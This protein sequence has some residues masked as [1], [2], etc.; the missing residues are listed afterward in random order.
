MT[1]TTDLHSRAAR[2]PV[3][4]V[5]A[6][7]LVEITVI[8]TVF[9]HFIAFDCRQN[10]PAEYCSAASRALVAIYCLLGVAVLLRMLRPAPLATLMQA[11]GGRQ[12]PLLINAA[13]VAVALIPLAFLNGA[14]GSDA[15]LPA[16][17]LW[18]AGM[19]L[20]LAGVA[21]FIAPL[22]RWGAY[23]R[24][25]W[26]TILPA[27]VLASA[28]PWISIQLQPIWSIAWIADRT[29]NAVAALMERFGYDLYADPDSKVIG[30]GEFYVIVDKVCSGIEG[31]ALVTLFVS[32]YL[33][34]F[35]RELRFP[36]A[37]LLYPIG[38]AA[39]VTFNVIRITV[40]LII[41]LEGNPELAV[42][43]FH[44][45]AGWMMFTVVALGLIAF[46]QMV[47][48]LRKPSV[49]FAATHS[50]LPPFWRDPTVAMILPFIVFMLSALL[51]STLSQVPS[52]IY[53]AR[54]AVMVAVMALLLPFYRS[55]TWRIDSVAVGVGI[56]IAAYWVLIPV[57]STASAAPYGTLSGALLLGWFVARGVGTI[58]LVPIIEELFFRG[59]LEPRLRLGGGLPWMIG[60]ALVSAALF[61][62]LHGRVAE[63]FVAGLLFSWVAARR[64]TVTDAIIAH[65]VANAL[66]FFTAIVASN[67]AMI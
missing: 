27:G 4:A 26:T 63:A 39:S 47:P 53:P 59:Y 23:L 42:G 34:L 44:S 13:G 14:Q 21:L 20:M 2:L 38:I 5:L 22:S 6:L 54:V 30:A 16:L 66:I 9:K 40:L 41:G 65:S 3:L 45:H 1:M 32:L 64:G 60:A 67:M 19:S 35:R 10:W 48:V 43:G 24:S 57:E 61:A 58:A 51:A 55:L 28:A 29:F 46:A 11:A 50:P 31:I 49:G 56:F 7:L 52:A 62:A 18:T 17:A 15:A 12:W 8:G 33:W 37:L 25:E 36:M